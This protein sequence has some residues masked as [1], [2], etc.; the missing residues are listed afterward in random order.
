[1]R[2]QFVLFSL[3]FVLVKSGY[4]NVDILNEKG[5]CNKVNSFVFSHLIQ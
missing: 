4:K 1:M 5:R 3:V 2:H